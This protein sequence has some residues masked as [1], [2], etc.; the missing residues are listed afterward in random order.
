MRDRV[1]KMFRKTKSVLF[2]DPLSFYK[3]EQHLLNKSFY[4]KGTNNKAILLIHGW[5]SVPYEVRRL[6]KYL[7][8]SGYT[9][10]GPMLKGHGTVPKDLENVKWK[11]WFDDFERIYKKIRENHTRVYIGGTSIGSNITMLLAKKY[12]EISGIIL[13]ATP[14]QMKFEKLKLEKIVIIILKIMRIFKKYNRKFYFPTFDSRTTITR[15]ISY[16]TYPIESI[17]EAAKLI[18]KSRE[19][20]SEITQPCF[21]LQSSSDCIVSKDSLEKIYAQINSKIKKKK[22]IKRAYHTF[23]S[24]V[25]NEYVLKYIL[26]FL[27]KI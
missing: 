9:V 17:F 26:N 25:K 16:Q 5:T 27:N 22:Y 14:Y 4:F 20:L 13:M 15:L 3:K 24:D 2:S 7:N 8:E 23:I 19:N 6:G 10:Y 11:E 21:L 18:E 1:K 12:P